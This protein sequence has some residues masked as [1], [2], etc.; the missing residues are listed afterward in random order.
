[1]NINTELDYKNFEDFKFA[2]HA[3]QYI[4]HAQCK[5][6]GGPVIVSSWKD[7]QF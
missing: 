3:L 7:D 6:C 1:M 5:A 4:A 2:S